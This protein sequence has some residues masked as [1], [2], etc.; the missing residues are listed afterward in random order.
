MFNR[1]EF[2]QVDDECDSWLSTT[3]LPDTDHWTV[4]DCTAKT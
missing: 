1:E 4:A 2:E 3:D